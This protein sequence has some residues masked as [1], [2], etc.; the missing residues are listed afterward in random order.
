MSKCLRIP[1]DENIPTLHQEI[2]FHFGHRFG[3]EVS[4]T[5]PYFPRGIAAVPIKPGKAGVLG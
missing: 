2:N 1:H 3:N 4:S 5:L